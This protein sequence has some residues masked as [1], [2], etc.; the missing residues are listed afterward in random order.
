MLVT[1]G[2]TANSYISGIMSDKVWF[3]ERRHV[4]VVRYHA[5]LKFVGQANKIIQFY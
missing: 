4:R 1:A 2:V 3:V 5:K